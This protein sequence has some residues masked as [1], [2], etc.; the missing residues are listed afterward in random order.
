MKKI[1][2]L[3]LLFITVITV[4]SVNHVISD[5]KKLDLRAKRAKI[6]YK[7]DNMGYWTKLAEE[8]IIPFNPDVKPEPANFKG[9]KIKSYVV[10][11]EDSPDVPVTTLSSTQ[12]ENSIAVDNSVGDTIFNSNNSTPPN[13]Y[14]V[15]GADYLY[16]FDIAETWEGSI[17]GPN[18]NNW[19][20]PAAC[21]DNNGRW[22]VGY[23]STSGGQ[24]ISYSD[25]NGTNWTAKTVATAPGGWSSI[26]DKNHL[27]VD[28]KKGSPYENYIYDAW[29]DYGGIYDNEVVFK[30]SINR[31]VTWESKIP[32]SI[33]V[34]ALSHSQGVNLA[35][36]PN[37]EVYAA[38]AVYDNGLTEKAI[39]FCKST[40]GGESFSTAIRAINN[41]Y[42]I[43]S[44]GV[45]QNMRVNSFPAMAV[46]ISDGPYSGNIYIVWANRGLPGVNSGTD[47]SVYM[48]RSTDGGETWSPPIKVNQDSD[49]IGKKHFFPWIAVDPVTGVISV[50][51]Y[52]NRNTTY[53][54]MAEAWVAVSTNGGQTWDD[55]RVSDV[56]FTPQ[57]IPGLADN[58]FGDYL[59]IA[60]YNGKVYPVW[61]DNRTGKAM[62]YVSPFETIVINSPYNL[63][64]NINQETG[65]C[66]LQWNHEQGNG[67][68]QYFIYKNGTLIDSTT[69][70]SYTDTVTVYSYLTYTVTA[71]YSN[72]EESAPE[73]VNTQYGSSVSVFS[74]DSVVKAV[75]LNSIEEEYLQLS[76]QGNLY[77]T[78]AISPF[79]KNVDLQLSSYDKASGG[80]DEYIK[81][82]T[83]AD[84]DNFTV[85]EN[86]RNFNEIPVTVN[87][88][89]SYEITVENGNPYQ[90]DKCA[91]WIDKN[92]DGKFNEQPIILLPDESY[93]TFK[94]NITFE[95]GYK[96]MFYKMRVRLAGP[97]DDLKPY[98][99]TKYGEVEDYTLLIAPW[100]TITPDADTIQV[101]DTAN[102]TFVFDDA[103][104]EAGVYNTAVTFLLSDLENHNKMIKIIMAV[105]DLNVEASA[106]NSTVCQ[107]TE[108]QLFANAENALGT[109]SYE[110]SSVP[111][112]F[113]SNEQ[114]PLITADETRE[115]I[116]AVYD[117]L[118]IVKYDTV[119]VNVLPKP[120]VELGE[121][122]DICGDDASVTLDAGDDG[123]TYMWSTG[124][125]TQTLTVNESV[126]GYGSHE[127]YVKVTNENGCE[128]SDTIMV[129]IYMLPEVNLGND[130]TF[131]GQDMSEVVLNAGDHGTSYLWSTG[132][133]TQTLSVSKEN[134][135]YGEHEIYV[136]VYSENGCENSDTIIVNMKDCS[137]INEHADKVNVNAYPNPTT[138]IFTLILNSKDYETVK[139]KV[140]S[141]TGTL[142]YSE[143]NVQ[144]NGTLKKK[145]DLNNASAGVY[146]IFID[147]KNYTITKKI[148]LSK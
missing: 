12:S 125:T 89:E 59:G 51:F 40:N 45:P 96:H 4:L 36:G 102:I 31:G 130:T 1:K 11:S 85:S 110:W 127:I 144:I 86:Y 73:S 132:D 126:L 48:I 17:Y 137:S 100:L 9:S 123:T 109:L 20:D 47:I 14:S 113:T 26:C 135:D 34:N 63:S 70:L 66:F 52:D 133:T 143:N 53:P 65:I 138:G 95:K 84:L 103:E 58:Y 101:N 16:S 72:Q 61:T 99:D 105:T 6:N 104:M 93:K 142:I 23:I 43:R 117:T 91:I 54:N 75:D 49:N 67:F 107:G 60:A 71:Y 57:P 3:L 30:R 25:N 121:E 56:E 18:G 15:Y 29:T 78:Y 108:V 27:W 64:A 76:N 7:I 21:I 140:I 118:T 2:I 114:N 141:I 62:A 116:V 28:T 131:C 44:I 42:G 92:N 10:K 8:G 98:G 115:Y 94:G 80:G 39:G 46:D 124:D 22:Y 97:D 33:G 139:I 77:L 148:I 87:N 69:N 136:T 55:F 120:V 79:D 129:N 19:G 24:K 111:E 134:F 38:W 74:K 32:L 145:I 90:N 13:G 122:V 5:N 50:I 35:T 37:G 81:R 147:G 146:T 83:I 41:I 128:N 106:S 119:N 88:G 112:G 82:V 68:I